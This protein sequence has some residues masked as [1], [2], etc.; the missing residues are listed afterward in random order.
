MADI[1]ISKKNESFLYIDCE[2][3]I[4]QELKEHFTFMVEGAKY[5]PKFKAKIWDGTISL[6]DLRFGTLPAGLYYE[7]IDFAKKL[8]YTTECNETKYGRPD[9]VC[10]ASIEDVKKFV[11]GL[12]IHSKNNKLEVRDYQIQ[13]IYNC[14]R[15]QRQISITPTGGGKSLIAYC[16][17][18]WYLEHGSRHFLLVVPNLGLVKQMYAD[19]KDYSSHNEFDVESTTQIIAEGQSK[20]IHKS[21]VISTWQ[22][23]YK[24]PHSWFNNNID[25]IFADEV[26]QYK[27][28]AMKG[29]FEKSTEVKYRI[30]VTGSLDKS[31]S[32]KMV[33]RGLI[34]EISKVKSTRDL[35]NEG[36]LSE[37]KI[38]CII[39]KYNKDTQKMMK[40][41]EY[42][43]E[44]DFICDHSL[45]N[46]FIRKLALSRKG[47]TLVL[48]NYVDKHGEPL[49]EEINAHATTQNVHMVS[50]KVEANERELIR[51][52]VQN[53]TGDNIICASAGT[54]STGINLPRIHTIIF[55]SPTKSIIRVMQ[56]I[57]RGLRK[58]DDKEFL[59]LFD[60]C[61]L[62][63]PSK[64][65]PNHTYRHFIERL[66]I[67]A[68]EGHPYEIV[69]V[70]IE[71]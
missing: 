46:K 19:F 4:L 9:D 14:I 31:L 15:N 57:G 45:R 47:N 71:K 18:R 6:L 67:Y 11:M 25:V 35:I 23:I 2:L 5:S 61:D 17:Y 69:E 24:Q 36:H 10:D 55:A 20:Q 52:L 41:A 42:Q 8:G 44:I 38:N 54:F 33:L 53:S 59:M 40:G 48:F 62:L 49:Y 70:E 12:N 21:L 58:A 68:E 66:R 28:D 39:L 7:L 37:I 63:N 43:H 56:S 26:H 64:A 29:I 34:G 27:A 13:A 30:G 65:K 32:N 16:L 51:Q 60:L 22:S 50:G 1:T 3:G